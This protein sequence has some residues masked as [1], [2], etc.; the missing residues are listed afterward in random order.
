MKVGDYFFEKCR[1]FVNSTTEFI[2]RRYDALERGFLNL[3]Y[4]VFEDV[5]SALMNLR[6]ENISLSAEVENLKKLRSEN[7]E[8]RKLLSLKKSI[9]YSAIA[10]KVI[11][12]F[13]NDFT[14][15]ILLN[16]GKNDGVSVG[17]LVINCDGLVGRI[18]ETNDAHSRALLITDMN[19]VIPVKIGDRQ[20][21]AIMTGGGSDK[22]WISA[23]REDVPIEEGEV[24]KTSA[25]GICE[26]IPVGTIKKEGQKLAVKS[27]VA[28][29][30]LKHVIVL[31]KED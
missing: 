6:N 25:Y 23:L 1:F 3:R 24:V 21:N 5:H 4:F 16:V 30:L 7:E 26:D 28:F 13:S 9:R 12:I 14:R 20:I 31:K 2:N 22:L 19:A 18:L 10:A 15:S 11:N 29:H 17:D 27:K 8:L